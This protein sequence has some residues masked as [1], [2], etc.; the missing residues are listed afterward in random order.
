[1]RS[2]PA[3]SF[4]RLSDLAMLWRAYL[5][6]RRGKRRTP[7]VA[8]FDLD[9]DLHIAALQR[10]LRSGRYAPGPYRLRVIRDP[11]L[12]LIAAA[13]LRDRV[14]HQAVIGELGPHYER[15]FS[16]H[17][18]ACGTGRGPHRALLQY[19]R[20]TRQH[21]FRVSLDV[22]RYFPSIRHQILLALLRH[23][24][25]D[26][27]TLAL[28]E[29]IIRAGG[30]VYRSA[31]A[32]RALGLDQ[33]PLPPDCGL[34]IG[35]YVSQW[36]G[37]LYLDGLDHYVKRTLKIPGYLRYMDDFSLF[38]DDRARLLGA[39]EAIREWLFRERGLVLGR[40]RWEV[41][42]AR[43]PSR[44]VGYRISRAGTAPGPKVK[45]RLKKRLRAAAE[46]GPDALARSLAS[47]RGVFLF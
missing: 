27:K 3:G 11:K 35:S 30:S 5:R 15:S 8:R 13:P 10:E 6:C 21:R 37:A 19:L 1:M 42:D 18:F 32:V 46:R 29:Q 40:R 25:R 26:E 9:A 24:L 41:M 7:V 31:L 12:R 43:E 4:D 14:I 34:A 17:S 47:Y 28:L 16:E 36:S 2:V 45:R 33:D 22:K 39:R 23:R 44:F 20:L 38:A